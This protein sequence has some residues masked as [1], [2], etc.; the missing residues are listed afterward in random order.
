MDITFNCDKCGQSLTIDE[1]GAG[2]LVD[3]PKCG[4]PLEVPYKNKAIP[5]VP[6]PLQSTK[7]TGIVRAIL[8]VVGLVLVGIPLTWLAVKEY[9]LKQYD[10]KHELELKQYWNKYNLQVD[11]Q[12]AEIDADDQK[13]ELEHPVLQVSGQ[14]FVV[15]GDR[16]TIKLSLQDIVVVP[17]EEATNRIAR[18]ENDVRQKLPS[19]RNDQLITSNDLEEITQTLDRLRKDFETH[20]TAPGHRPR[21]SARPAHLDPR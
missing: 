19:A 7:K 16:E 13:H 20:Q 12:N 5:P 6:A 4:I 3:C 11:K 14:I 17:E 10:R 15:R 21:H 1:A 8:V 18:V 9:R 2:Q